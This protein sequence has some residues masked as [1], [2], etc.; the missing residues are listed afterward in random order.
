LCGCFW[1]YIMIAWSSSID[2]RR[3]PEVVFE[4]L[5]NIQDV[6]QP[7]DSP[8]LALD[9]ITEG[10]PGLGSRYREVVQMM[11]LIKGE[12]LSEISVFDAPGVLA[13]RWRG[14]GMGGTD[15]Y[16]LEC[17]QDGTRLHHRR[18]MSCHGLLRVL[19]PFMRI[20][21]IPRLEER[22]VDIQRLLEAGDDR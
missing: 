10:P 7:A 1:L 19:E 6:P 12:F 14:P 20:P 22:L 11:P 15:R 18:H 17:I 9:L 13:L 8:V 3:P 5:A 2:I 4:F 21:L 16:Q